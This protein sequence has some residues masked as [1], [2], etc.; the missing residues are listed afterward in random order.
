MLGRI[1][2]SMGK[3]ADH[4]GIGIVTG[5][6]KVVGKGSADQLFVNTAGVG[7]IPAG[8]DIGPERACVGDDIIVSGALGEHGVAIMSVRAGIDFGTVVTT[9]S[10]PL[11]RLVAAMLAARGIKYDQQ[12]IRDLA[13]ELRELRGKEAQPVPADGATILPFKTRAA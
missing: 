1:A 3:A 13:D 10:A 7:V 12:V 5:D 8:V 4:A 6:T 9:D 2:Q 11:H